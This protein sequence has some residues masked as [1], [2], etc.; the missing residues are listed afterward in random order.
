MLEG[1]LMR[2]DL[3]DMG[4]I[5]HI[6]QLTSPEILKELKEDSCAALLYLFHSC[7]FLQSIRAS[8][9]SKPDAQQ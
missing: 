4:S 6:A 9:A 5:V 7:T 1:Q 3:C 2:L 8:E